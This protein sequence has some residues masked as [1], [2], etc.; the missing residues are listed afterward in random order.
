MARQEGE[1]WGTAEC[2]VCGLRS[3]LTR[4]ISLDER[5]TIV[6]ARVLGNCGS[7]IEYRHPACA[8][9]LALPRRR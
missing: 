9:N 5:R 7:R 8:N 4:L 3:L 1:K 6:L 2:H